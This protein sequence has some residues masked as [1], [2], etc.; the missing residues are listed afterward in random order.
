MLHQQGELQAEKELAT[1]SCR[2]FPGVSSDLGAGLYLV[3]YEAR[4]LCGGSLFP[5]LGQERK[6]MGAEYLEICL[7]MQGW[8]PVVLYSLALLIPGLPPY[9]RA[10]GIRRHGE[11]RQKD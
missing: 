11:W 5:C 9:Q 10:V 4:M 1:I 3:Q 2:S 8:I 6:L 7:E